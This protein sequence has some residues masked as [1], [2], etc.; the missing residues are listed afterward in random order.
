MTHGVYSLSM[1]SLAS[2]AAANASYKSASTHHVT[3][4]IVTVS[5][6]EYKV[7]SL[8]YRRTP[9]TYVVRAV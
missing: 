9:V 6:H 7:T 1:S 4:V 8:F 3:G 2:V 5:R